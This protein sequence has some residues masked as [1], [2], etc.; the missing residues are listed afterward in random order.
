MSFQPRRWTSAWICLSLLL[1]SALFGVEID[2]VSASPL[3]RALSLLSSDFDAYAETIRNDWGVPGISVSIVKLANTSF[4]TTPTIET[5][6]YG[7]A[8]TD[9]PVDALTRFGIASNS[10][11]FTAGAIGSL[12][13]AGKLNWTTPVKEI[14]PEFGLLNNYDGG[15]A[16]IRDLLS[17]RTG[18]P[19]HDY[20]IPKSGPR[21]A[22]VNM[23]QYLQ[24]SAEFRDIWQYSN[25][26]FIVVSKIV[27]TVAGKPFEDY[28]TSHIFKHPALN[29]TYTSYT[30]DN[31]YSTGYGIYENKSTFAVPYVVQP[32]GAGAAGVIT[33]AIDVAKWMSFL[34]KSLMAA[35]RAEL[36]AG[37]TPISPSSVGNLAIGRM[38]ESGVPDWPELSPTAYGYG[39]ESVTYQ[40]HHLWTHG[41]DLPG[42]GSQ[43]TWVPESGVGVAVFCNTNQEPGAAAAEIITYRALEDL[44]GLPHPN[45]EARYEGATNGTSGGQVSKRSISRRSFAARVPSH[46]HSDITSREQNASNPDPAGYI[47]T[48]T[49]GGY[50][51]VTVCP[52]SDVAYHHNTP[53]TC[54]DLYN[55]L[56]GGTQTPEQPATDSLNLLIYAPR[57]WSDYIQL[58]SHSD[59][60][61]VGNTYL[62]AAA[63]HERPWPISLNE[64]EM[65][66]IFKFDEGA[67]QGSIVGMEWSG[68]WGSET[69]ESSGYPEVT[70]VR[71]Q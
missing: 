42:F 7:V 61:F 26:M 23:V 27:E 22:V 30:Q 17:H 68:V 28:V 48:Y 24:P 12:V 38:L 20:S 49:N 60:L 44:L 8:G 37:A 34:I 18:L 15:L 64:G 66:A 21:D 54:Q 29:M 51:D 6:S 10:K 1:S 14:L 33:N 65:L 36:P 16:T 9:R 53:S 57:L 59:A 58:V 71:A 40:G 41:G 39:L 32:V 2:V 19:R 52:T 5:R 25:V 13:D 45:W 46:L 70:F 31:L 47:G 3:P 56:K 35:G 62:I 43:I 50:G 63:T 11:L 69:Q 67:H 4:D 55:S